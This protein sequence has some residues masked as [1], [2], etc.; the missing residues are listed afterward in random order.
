[1]DKW[2]TNEYLSKLNLPGV[3]VPR[4]VLSKI[5]EIPKSSSDIISF[6]GSLT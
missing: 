6:W 1:M 3:S 4:H 2:K 5:S